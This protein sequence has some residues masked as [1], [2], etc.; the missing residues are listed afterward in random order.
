VHRKVPAWF[1][2]RPRGKGPAQQAPR[3][4]AHP[5][6]GR[7]DVLLPRRPGRRDLGRR[8]GPH[9]PDRPRG[10]CRRHDQTP[11]RRGRLPRQRTHRRR[12]RGRLPHPQGPVPELRHRP[13]QRLADRHRNHRGRGTVSDQ[14][15]DGH[16]RRPVEHPRRRSRP[17][18][19]RRHR[20]RRLRRVLAMA[21][22]AGTTP[23]PPR[24]LPRTR[25][26]SLTLTSLQ[27]SHTH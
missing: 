5:V 23:Q 19:P 7:L 3:R 18:A 24:P 26:C 1:G 14:G 13:G 22:A 11:G 9:H 16:H 12:R 2:G 17:P 25:S 27:K 4:A 10:R 8:P 6:E 21:P 20:Q 15:P